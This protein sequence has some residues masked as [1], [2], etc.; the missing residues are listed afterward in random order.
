MASG[1]FFT[2]LAKGDTAAAA[3]LEATYQTPFQAHATLEPMNCTARVADGACEIWAPTQ[4]VDMAQAVAA[5]VTGLP[6]DKIVIHR[7]LIGGGFGRRLLADFVKQTLL[8]A[9]AVKR[10]VKL[11][12]SREEDMSHDF[13]RPAALHKISGRLD[14]AG[15]LVSLAHR[16]VSPSHMLYII[17]R[18][19]FPGIK[20]WTD[21]AAPPEKIDT[22]A[23]EGLLELPYAIPNQRVEQ[24]RLALDVRARDAFVVEVPVRLHADHHPET[25]SVVERH[26]GGTCDPERNRLPGR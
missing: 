10:P 15:A 6:S 13:Y 18:R 23:V 12:W 20:D 8:V 5:Q 17:P 22:M 11:I 26:G 9:M 3:T 7:T 24:H 21:P 2:H 19:L 25:D 16:V 4:G 1:P 14:P